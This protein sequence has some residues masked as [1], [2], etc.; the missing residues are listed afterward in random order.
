LVPVDLKLSPS[1]QSQPPPLEELD[2]SEEH[3]EDELDEPV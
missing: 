2:E 1:D 3:D